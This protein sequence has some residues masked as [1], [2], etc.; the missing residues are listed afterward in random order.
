[1]V[2]QLVLSFFFRNALVPLGHGVYSV[3]RALGYVA[4]VT[5][6]ALGNVLTSGATAMYSYILLPF[7]KGVAMVAN[8]VYVVAAA[9]YVFV[10]QPCA[11]GLHN[12][13]AVT[14]EALQAVAYTV[15]RNGAA[16]AQQIFVYVIQPS[17]QAV[18]VAAV[19]SGEVVRTC[20]QEVRNAAVSAQASIGQAFRPQR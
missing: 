3:L 20:G 2:S 9:V 13:A 8:G 14:A 15:G 11:R 10:L 18:C 7:G 17:G 12:T 16:G 5:L 6:K 1:M 4:W 19:A